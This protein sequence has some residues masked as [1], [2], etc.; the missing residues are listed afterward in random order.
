MSYIYIIISG[1]KIQERKEGQQ[2]AWGYLSILFELF[3]EKWS[4]E[5]LGRRK[6]LGWGGFKEFQQILEQLSMKNTIKYDKV[7]LYCAIK[8]C[9]NGVYS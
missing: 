4:Q 2:G 8:F 6:I 5:S 1:T 9:L 3:S 7:C